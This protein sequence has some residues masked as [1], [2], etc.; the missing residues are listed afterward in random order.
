MTQS[1][2]VLSASLKITF[3]SYQHRT[4]LVWIFFFNN[5]P[6]LGRVHL[7]L[8]PGKQA[9]E[10]QLLI[11]RLTRLLTLGSLRQYAERLLDSGRG[12]DGPRSK[13]EKMIYG[14]HRSNAF[15]EITKQRSAVNGYTGMLKQG[16]TGAAERVRECWPFVKHAGDVSWRVRSREYHKSY[17]S[18]QLMNYRPRNGKII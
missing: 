6:W 7:G 15:N 18:V 13:P 4:L 14:L 11:S 16:Q 2:S 8:T 12:E 3:P 17:K 9:R 5:E 1:L 10:V